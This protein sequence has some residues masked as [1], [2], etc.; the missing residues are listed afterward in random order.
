MNGGDVQDVPCATLRGSLTTRLRART[1]TMFPEPVDDDSVAH[2]ADDVLKLCRAVREAITLLRL[3]E[4]QRA[5][6]LAATARAEVAAARTPVDHIGIATHLRSM[7]YMLVELADGPFAAIMA[8][9]AAR[10][11][12]D[13]IGRMFS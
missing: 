3:T 11:L 12:G 8:D 13:C 10:I 9:S 4:A 2:R 6:L 1:S 7:R 5:E